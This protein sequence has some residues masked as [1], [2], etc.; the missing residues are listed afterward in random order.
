MGKVTATSDD[1]YM[2][3]ALGFNPNDTTNASANYLLVDWKRSN[4]FVNFGIDSCGPGTTALP[5]LAVSRVTGIPTSEELWGHTDQNVSCSAS[6]QGLTELARATNLGSAGWEVGREYT[7]A[8][9]F[10]GTSLKVFV[11][12]VLE[13][14]ISGSF[15]GGRLA[16]YA[17]A[18]VTLTFSEFQVVELD[19]TPPAIVPH[20]DRHSGE[21]WLA[22]F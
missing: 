10:N 21:Q 22:R 2:G 18:Q 7:F 9:E 8:F 20:S 4:Q 15:S 13:I 12:G 14:D 16:F 11:D 3:F 17:F 1:D 5:G 19:T 6:G